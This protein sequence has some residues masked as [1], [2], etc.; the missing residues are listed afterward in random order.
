[1]RIRNPPVRFIW[2]ILPFSSQD[3]FFDNRD[4]FWYP[5][6]FIFWENKVITTMRQDSLPKIKTSH[7]TFI[8]LTEHFLLES[9][10]HGCYWGECTG[11]DSRHHCNDNN[12]CFHQTSCSM[13]SS[14]WSF[15]RWCSVQP[16]NACCISSL[17]WRFISPPRSMGRRCFHFPFLHR[18]STNVCSRRERELSCAS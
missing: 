2:S 6:S 5:E 9:K 17:H 7:L 4:H 10:I 1:M 8:L 15:S 18:I 12:T 16:F 11:Y 3:K 13:H 14:F